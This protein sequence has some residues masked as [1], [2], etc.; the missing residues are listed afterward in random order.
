MLRNHGISRLAGL[1]QRGPDSM[2]SSA[3][4][5]NI[6]TY[7]V[8]RLPPF[9]RGVSLEQDMAGAPPCGV[10]Q[11]MR[12]PHRGG[13]RDNC[14]M[15]VQSGGL[16]DKPTNRT[17]AGHTNERCRF[18]SIL[19]QILV[20]FNMLCFAPLSSLKEHKERGGCSKSASPVLDT[21]ISASSRPS[22]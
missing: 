13:L 17:I 11:Q 10:S 5:K 7:L 2:T 15:K 16:T 18:N 8:G 22:W 21:I 12:L 20:D 4:A 9:R 6:G 1:N 3:N 19:V 14:H